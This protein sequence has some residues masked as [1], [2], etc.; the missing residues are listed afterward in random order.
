MDNLQLL[1]LLETVESDLQRAKEDVADKDEQIDKYL[2]SF[3]MNQQ[4]L[5]QAL[6]NIFSVSEFYK[7]VLQV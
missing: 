5:K 4:A 6:V 2:S 3:K 1:N 7:Q